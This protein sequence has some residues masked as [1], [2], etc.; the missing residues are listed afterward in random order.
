MVSCSRAVASRWGDE[1]GKAVWLTLA[2]MVSRGTAL[3]RSKRRIRPKLQ[4]FPSQPTHTHPEMSSPV[5]SGPPKPIPLAQSAW[6]HSASE[7]E[8]DFLT[9][10][11]AARSKLWWAAPPKPRR[12]PFLL[13]LLSPLTAASIQLASHW[14]SSHT[15]VSM[16]LVLIKTPPHSVRGQARPAVGSFYLRT[17]AHAVFQMGLHSEVLGV[18]NS[19]DY[20]GGGCN[21]QK[22]KIKTCCCT[23]QSM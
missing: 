4:G 15:W 9:A 10:L 6:P 20:L 14:R 12:E 23:A 3:G 13:L 8:A 11:Q 16:G 18:R 7:T 22:L 2:G 17:S 5:P 21:P 19:A 1:R